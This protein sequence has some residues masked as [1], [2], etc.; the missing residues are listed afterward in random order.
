MKNRSNIILIGPMASGKTA[1]GNELSHITGFKSNPVDKLKWYYRLQNGYDLVKSQSILRSMGFE[2]LLEYAKPYFTP[3]DLKE[4][5][6]DFSGIIDLG[7]TDT[8]SNDLNTIKAI[9]EVLAPYPNIFLILPYDDEQLSKSVLSKRLIQRYKNDSLKGPVL[10][11]YLK[12]NE[13]FL[14][15]PQNL[16]IAK[17]VI[18]CNDRPFHQIAQE[19]IYK[20]DLRNTPLKSV[21]KVS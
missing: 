13:E 6:N 10:S 7:A 8:H 21:T 20:S 16:L 12:K 1:I 18:Y 9:N 11:T 15:S 2:A 5:L 19:I 14:M 17:H 3:N 4:L